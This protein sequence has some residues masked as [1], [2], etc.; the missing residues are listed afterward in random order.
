MYRV[1]VNFGN[2]KINF[3]VCKGEK[4]L[5][6]CETAQ[7]AETYIKFVTNTAKSNTKRLRKAV[8]YA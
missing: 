4:P 7:E 8:V 1:L 6:L 3:I 2:G 5:K